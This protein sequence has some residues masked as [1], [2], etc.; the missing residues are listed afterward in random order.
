MHPMKQTTPT[1]ATPPTPS[2]SKPS[3]NQ[4][5][6]RLNRQMLTL[7]SIRNKLKSKAT[8]RSPTNDQPNHALTDQAAEERR[9]IQ[10]ELNDYLAEPCHSLGVDVK[11]PDIL[12][13]WQMKEHRFPRLFKVAMTVLAV[14]ATSVPSERVFSSAGHTH[15]KS[16]NRVSPTLMEALQVLKFNHRNG[17]LDFSSIFLN[18]P[19]DMGGVLLDEIAEDELVEGYRNAHTLST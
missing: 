17:I 11:M 10:L 13:Y 18:D 5:E 3:A 8:A 7:C 16:R 6:Q 14:P 9:L 1:S 15:T 2:T 4:P 12:A 19:E